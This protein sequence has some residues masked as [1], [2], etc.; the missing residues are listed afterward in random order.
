MGPARREHAAHE[1]LIS[2]PM[3]AEVPLAGLS[4]KI[5]GSWTPTDSYDNKPPVIEFTP[6]GKAFIHH[7]HLGLDLV[8]SY[9]VSGNKITLTPMVRDTYYSWKQ[10]VIEVELLG[11]DE[12]IW[13][14]T[15]KPSDPIES[16]IE[17]LLGKVLRVR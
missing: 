4:S 8:A 3:L 6:G 16:E 9:K 12:M 14:L 1:S 15:A 10:V 5:I 13:T 17:D 7:A 2:R 11:P